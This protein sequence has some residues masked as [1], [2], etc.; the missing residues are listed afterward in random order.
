MCI[1]AVNWEFGRM[2]RSGTVESSGDFSFKCLRN[3]HVDLHND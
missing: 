2:P 1:S 3:L